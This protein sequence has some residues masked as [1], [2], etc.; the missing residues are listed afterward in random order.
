MSDALAP[1]PAAHTAVEVLS[2]HDITA[3][4][5]GIQERK[6]MHMTSLCPDRCNHANAWQLFDVEHYHAYSKPGKYGD[7]QGTQFALQIRPVDK[8][9][10]GPG[11]RA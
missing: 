5:A 10:H 8:V 3:R 4:Y 2:S 6:C 7:E 9:E 1:Q 11:V